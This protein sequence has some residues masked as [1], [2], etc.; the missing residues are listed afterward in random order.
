MADL[1]PVV[2][3]QLSS[4]LTVAAEPLLDSLMEHQDFSKVWLDECGLGP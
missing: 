4:Q 1:D 3:S 2:L